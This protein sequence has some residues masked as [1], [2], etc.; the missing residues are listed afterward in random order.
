MSVPRLSLLGR[1]GTVIPLWQPGVCRDGVKLT[2]RPDVDFTPLRLLSDRAVGQIGATPRGVVVEAKQ[3]TLAVRVEGRGVE[4]MTYHFLDTLRNDGQTVWLQSSAGRALGVV[5]V[6]CSQIEWQG[7]PND[8]AAAVFEV[9][10]EVPRP[11]WG[12]GTT[13]RTW[14]EGGVLS[15]P[16][17]GPRPVWPNIYVRGQFGSV[18]VGWGGTS[19]VLPYR[20]GGYRIITDPH[21]RSVTGTAGPSDPVP[22]VGDM[23]PHWT[24]PPVPRREGR[25][26]LLDMNVNVQGAGTDFQISI[27]A[28]GEADR[29]WT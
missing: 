1:D 4:R 20:E 3:L 17:N 23:V 28:T 6:G 29:A 15:L 14:T 10:L 19:A 25:H 7:N 21:R 18:T 11:V 22:V 16:V 27:E 12:C 26:Y 9:E 5:F 2:A 13:T 8:P 24:H